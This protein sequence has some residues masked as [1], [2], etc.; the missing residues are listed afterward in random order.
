MKFILTEK[1]LK[2]F[3]SLSIS[4]TSLN[5]ATETRLL[6]WTYRW[7]NVKHIHH[8]EQCIQISSSPSLLAGVEPLICNG[9]QLLDRRCVHSIVMMQTWETLHGEPAVPRCVSSYTGDCHWCQ[10]SK[11]KTGVVSI[12]RQSMTFISWCVMR[13]QA[14]EVG[15]VSTRTQVFLQIKPFSPRFGLSYWEQSFWKL[16][17]GWIRSE[18]RFQC[19]QRFL[20][21]NDTDVSLLTG[22][23]QCHIGVFEFVH[24]LNCYFVRRYI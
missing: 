11:N 3:R 23:H 1:C 6:A 20:G 24:E 22:P 10:G 9:L 14:S 4:W 8:S 21:T 16:Q 15:R 5:S 18:C 2:S 12:L 13:H 7:A 19:L 17:P